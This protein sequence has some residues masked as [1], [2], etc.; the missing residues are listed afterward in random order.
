MKPI[1]SIPALGALLLTATAVSTPA[2]ACTPPGPGQC[3][4]GAVFRENGYYCQVTTCLSQSGYSAGPQRHCWLINQPVRP[5]YV[6]RPPLAG[7]H[8]STGSGSG[9]STH[10]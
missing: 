3:C 9:G 7:S 10:Q 5:I 4:S 2:S 8:L 1:I 6:P